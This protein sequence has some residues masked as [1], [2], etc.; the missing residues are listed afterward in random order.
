VPLTRE[1]TSSDAV[2][3]YHGEVKTSRPAWHFT[4]RARPVRDGVALPTELPLISW[5][6]RD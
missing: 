3:H 6:S 1:S 5:G 2:A 4:A